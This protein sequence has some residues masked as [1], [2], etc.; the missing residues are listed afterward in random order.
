MKKNLPPLA[1]AL[2]QAR[3]RAGLSQHELANAA[4]VSRPT[5]A[6]IETG[7]QG[8]ARLRTLQ[9][10]ATALNCP[11]EAL[12]AAP[13]TAAQAQLSGAG[14]AVTEPPPLAALNLSGTERR[15]LATAQKMFG[16]RR[17]SSLSLALLILALR[18]S[19]PS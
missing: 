19:E 15:W 1:V 13:Q 6:N 8:T 12:T 14:R 2:R 17:P 4:G 9:Q 5:V 11:L 7:L 16:N 3:A 18:S 10:L